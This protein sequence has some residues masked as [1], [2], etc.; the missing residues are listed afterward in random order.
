[1]AV[2][3]A[4]APFTV[5]SLVNFMDSKEISDEVRDLVKVRITNEVV[6]WKTAVEVH[7]ALAKLIIVDV[8]T[9]LTPEI[10]REVRI[11]NKKSYWYKTIV[12]NG[13]DDKILKEIAQLAPSWDH[14]AYK[15]N[16][17]NDLTKVL[18]ELKTDLNRLPSPEKPIKYFRE[19]RSAIVQRPGL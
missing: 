3:K 9:A 5:T 10:V 15:A 1:M 17:L 2:M 14:H 12:Y 19:T 11:L 13:G 18:R 16:D 4:V 6:S 7:A 8:S